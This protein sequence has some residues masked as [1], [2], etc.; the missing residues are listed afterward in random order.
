M[1]VAELIKEPGN[2]IGGM[3]KIERY[4]WQI[5]DN[6]GEF[7]WIPK[8]LLHV[9]HTYQRENCANSKILK[10]AKDWSWVACNTLAVVQRDGN[11]Y[12]VVDGQHRKLAADKRSDIN[13]L[14]CMVY[15]CKGIPSE[16]KAFL[17]LNNA[18]TSVPAITKFKAKLAMNNPAAIAIQE[19]LATTGHRIAGYTTSTAVSCPTILMKSFSKSP[20]ITRSIWPLC[21]DIH[22]GEAIHSKIWEGLFY[23]E[24][25]IQPTHQ[26]LLDSFE[27]KKL[28]TAGK[29]K[30]LDSINKSVAFFIKGTPRVY[31]RGILNILNYKRRTN[32]INL[33]NE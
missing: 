22:N 10:Y 5:Q 23:I 33:P 11:Y 8:T 15:K 17:T 32:K 29:T 1:N 24:I 4:N 30:I 20:I 21:V 28:V 6:R 2:K 9:D 25:M 13:K 19:I 18:R 12:V 7:K 14:P 26:S 31:A 16:A 27:Y 3:T